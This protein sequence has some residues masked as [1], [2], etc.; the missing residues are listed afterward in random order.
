MYIHL[1]F[2]TIDGDFKLRPYIHLSFS[3]IDV[4]FKLRPDIHFGTQRLTNTKPASI[5]KK[6]T[7]ISLSYFLTKL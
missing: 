4:D 2:S 7:S 5:V 6:P 3:T 1:C